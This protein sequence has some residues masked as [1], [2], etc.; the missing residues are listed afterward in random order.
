MNKWIP[1][2]LPW[3]WIGWLAAGPLSFV[4]VPWPDDSA[5]YFVAKDF[6]NP[7][8]Y[9][10]SRWTMGP[11]SPFE[12][13]YLEWNFNTMP[14][15][16]LLIA[17]GKL[18][19]IDGV[20]TIKFWPLI[21]YGIS[22]TLLFQFIF[23]LQIN[24]VTKWILGIA[25]LLDPTLR[26]ASILVRPESLVGLA[27]VIIFL[28]PKLSAK[29][30]GAILGIAANAHFNAIHLV[31]P[32]AL[33]I[34]I[35]NSSNRDRLRE[36]AVTSV[37]ALLMLAPWLATVLAKPSLFMTQMELQWSR[38]AIA[39][40]W[41]HTLS[42]FLLGFFQQMGS[43]IE[44]GRSLMAVSI[45][46][47]LAILGGGY[48]VL[49]SALVPN[50]KANPQAMFSL[51]WVISAIWLWHTKPEVWF[52]YFLHLSLWTFI[53]VLISHPFVPR[54][55]RH[56]LVVGLGLTFLVFAGE[57]YGQSSKM[58][59]D[60]SFTWTTYHQ[61]IDCID[62]YLT[63]RANQIGKPETLSV[64]APTFPD[65]L[66][67]LSLRHPTWR[68]TRTNDFWKRENLALSHAGEVDAVVV[69]ETLQY[70]QGVASG[71]RSVFPEIQSVWMTW[72][73]HYL[74]KL[75]SDPKFKP[76]RHY[77]QV[78]RWQAFLYF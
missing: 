12:P 55:A 59:R 37:W 8:T 11:Q 35:R 54:F 61:Y 32:T 13:T 57:T 39:N 75:E 25:L 51:A 60:P 1:Y 17:A 68:L 21:F 46:F 71:P 65:I 66:I 77:C 58:A 26:W 53:T 64:W 16:P 2:V 24:R 28:R 20:H 56:I 7:P 22:L 3:V 14:L 30:I 41:T 9:A 48:F 38:L 5:F 74:H 33:L 73:G 70:T 62:K 10:E 43:P 72:K 52:T 18:V 40:D 23:N 15:Y 34:W 63:E 31:F 19:G 4:P 29:H 6:L 67:E 27:G 50:A 78:H 69:A 76:N 42:G 45:F 49:K 36:L 44:L 47:I